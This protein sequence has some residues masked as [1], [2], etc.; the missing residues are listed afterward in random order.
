M[1]PIVQK[2]VPSL[3]GDYLYCGKA[4]MI[5]HHANHHPE[6]D[7]DEYINIQTILDNYDDIKDL[8]DDGKL[9][10]AFVKKLDKCYAVVAELSK[11]NDKIVLH[12]TFFYR[13]AAGKR[14]PYKNKPSIL[15]RWSVDGSTTISPAEV[16]QPADTENISALDQSISVSK[17]SEN[18]SRYIKYLSNGK[19]IYVESE[20][21][22]DGTVLVSKNMWANIDPHKNPL[23]RWLM[24][25]RMTPPSSRLITLS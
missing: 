4:Y 8:S 22:L 2:N 20:G 14:V 17:D 25:V 21:N 15:E 1:P 19:I 13:D 11:E 3:D 24:L 10:I 7:I 18:P 5:D 6:L 16:Q 9:K 12:K 23:R